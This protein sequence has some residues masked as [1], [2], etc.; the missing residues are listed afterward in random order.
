MQTNDKDLKTIDR[1]QII[2]GA[3][4][5][6]TALALAPAVTACS[7]GA[8]GTAAATSLSKF[9]T[10]DAITK[11][12]KPDLPGTKVVAPAFFS[13][14]KN[15][16][17]SVT[18][19]IGSGSKL[20]AFALTYSQPPP[21]NSAFQQYIDGKA[22][23]KFDV[24]IVPADSFS[25]KFAT[26]MAGGNLPDIAQVPVWM[27]LPHLPQLMESQMADLTPY[28]SGNAVKKYPNLANLPPSSWVTSRI[29]GKIYGPPNPRSPYGNFLMTRP[30]LFDKLGVANAAPKNKSEF[31]ALC[32][33][34][35]SASA[36][37]YALAPTGSTNWASP[38]IYGMFG[39]PNHWKNDGGKLTNQVE[40]DEW[41]EAQTYTKKLWKMGVFHPDSPTL[42]IAKAKTYYQNGTVLMYCDGLAALMTPGLENITMDG[43]VPF[44]KDGGPGIVYQDAGSFSFTAIKKA[45]KARVEEILRV[46]NYLAAPFGSTE[47]FDLHFGKKSA[48]Y[49]V[50]SDGMPVLT[51][52]G[53]N[54][55]VP[56]SL[57]YLG[58]PPPVLYS[59][60]SSMKDRIKRSHALQKAGAG[61]LLEDPTLGLYSA[62]DNSSASASQ[63]LDDVSL[64][65]TLG[66]K[67]LGD[68][69]DAVASWKK[70]VGNKIR[71]EYEAALSKSKK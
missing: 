38:F 45:S 29:N 5:G 69:K 11:G 70:S 22:N 37:R 61:L 14:P 63:K 66:R 59:S 21:S 57:A 24:T 44:A 67:S 27:S 36:N 3:A 41:L 62:T 28:L 2:R 7:S 23:V 64:S 26:T 54:E 16:F 13:Y 9:P 47:Y 60:E 31:T 40:T 12:P 34:V 10:Y 43:M 35:T 68:L 1:R 25:T 48:D 49:T 30:D 33:E 71:S 42:T 55:I 8:G 20:S 18:G 50:G 58:G 53:G 6:L 56:S 39:V 32:K 46:L 51:K 52:K 4:L 15:S 65:Y 19:K 17:T